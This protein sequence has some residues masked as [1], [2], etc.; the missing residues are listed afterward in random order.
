MNQ[1]FTSSDLLTLIPSIALIITSICL[2]GNK[3][4]IASFL[5]S[6]KSFLF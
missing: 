1:L 6:A 5:K 2:I 3:N 4:K